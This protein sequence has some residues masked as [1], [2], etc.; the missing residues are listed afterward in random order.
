MRIHPPIKIAAL[1]LTGFSFGAPLH[2]LTRTGD[3]VGYSV[4]A[5]GQLFRFRPAATLAPASVGAPLG[6]GI[7]ALTSR[8]GRHFVAVEIGPSTSQLFTID[9]TSGARTNTPA[10]FATAG[11]ANSQPYDLGLAPEGFG[12]IFL[13]G[14]YG[15]DQPD[16]YRLVSA[17]ATNLR[18]AADGSVAARDGDFTRPDGTSDPPRIVAATVDRQFDSRAPIFYA[19]NAANDTLV[20]SADPAQGGLRTV[21]PLGVDIVGPAGLAIHRDVINQL[22]AYA[23]VTTGDGATHTLRTIDLQTGALSPP[24]ATFPSGFEPTGGLTLV[25]EF[26]PVPDFAVPSVRLALKREIKTVGPRRHTFRLRGQA[27]DSRG[28]ARVLVKEDGKRP[29]PARGTARWSYHLRLEPGRNGVRIVA[30]DTSGNRSRPV[31]IVIVRRREG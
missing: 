19:L 4:N 13:P 1:L 15:G 20:T 21:G 23:T 5:E 24:I 10:S 22:S 31:R 8:W 9:S 3:I 16:Q 28:I 7:H 18:L 26:G 14:P 17:N 11:T 27:I 25:E 29:R 30:I 2:A 6:P 12:L